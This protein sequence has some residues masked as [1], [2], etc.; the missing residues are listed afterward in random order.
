L[1]ARFPPGIAAKIPE[2]QNTKK[3]AAKKRL[4]EALFTAKFF[5]F[6]LEEL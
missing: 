6:W 4:R 3:L 1:I 5:V 2:S